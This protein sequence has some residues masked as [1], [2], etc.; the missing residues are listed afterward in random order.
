MNPTIN[1]IVAKLDD[2]ACLALAD[3]ADRRAAKGETLGPLHG[4]PIAFKDLQPAVGF[5]L[6][7]GSPIYKDF[8]PTEDSV[9]VERLRRAGV[10]AIGKTNT[11]GVRDGVAHLQPRLRHHAQSLRSDARAPAD[12]AAAPARRSPRACC[13]SPTAAT[14][15]ARCRNPGNFNNVVG[16]R[17]TVGLVP[18]APNPF[19]LFGFVDQRADGALGGRRRLAPERHGRRRSARPGLRALRSRQLRSAASRRDVRGKRIAWCPDLGGLPLDP[20]RA[21][22]ARGAAPDLRGA[23]LHRRGRR[24]RPAR[25]RL[26]SS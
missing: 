22:G 14:W 12:R 9:L 16:M 6:T 26:E 19:P 4:L 8:M 1:A 18:T 2:D 23:R 11:P 20:P 3:E 25:R 10:V 24:P 5:P 17:P 21:R 7:R 13:R 15:A